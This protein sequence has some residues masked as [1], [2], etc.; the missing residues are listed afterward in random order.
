[1]V[2]RVGTVFG[3]RGINISSMAVGHQMGDEPNGSAVMVVTT[4]APVPQEVVDEIVDTEG[5]AEGRSVTLH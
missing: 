4:D 3:E 1:M 5:F 2:G